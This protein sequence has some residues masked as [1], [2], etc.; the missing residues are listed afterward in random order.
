MNQQNNG[1]ALPDEDLAALAVDHAGLG[2][3]QIAVTSG[4]WR[5]SPR[6]KRLLG[7]GHDADPRDALGDE[8]RRRFAEA[9][10][11]ALRRG[12]FHLEFRVRQRW[13]AAVG[14]AVRAPSGIASIVGTLQ[15][16]TG[17]RVAVE[18]CLG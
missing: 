3:W 16:I 4:A 18:V 10:E 6:C 17:H 8:D 14:R 13:L 1:A 12:E 11:R 5:C 7:C 15:D 2:V 9:I